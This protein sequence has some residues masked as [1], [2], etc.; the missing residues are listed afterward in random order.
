M[1]KQTGYVRVAAAVPET[2]VADVEQNTENIKSVLRYVSSCRPDVIIFPELCLTSYT[3]GD[4]FGHRSLHDNVESGLLS[5]LD[6]TANDDT[7]IVVGAPLRVKSQ[8]FN[9][10]VVVQSGKIL[11][12]VPKSF[13]PNYNEYYEKRWF[14]P[15]SSADANHIEACGQ[16]VPFGADIVFQ[17]QAEAE[18]FTFAVELCEDLWAPIPPSTN[19]ALGGANIL[20]NISASNDLVGKSSYRRELVKHQS[21]RCLSAYA[22]CSAGVGESTTDMVFGGQCIIAENDSV[23]AESDRF[24]RDSHYTV[25]DIDTQLLTHERCQYTTF[26][27]AVDRI[28]RDSATGT[29]SLRDVRFQARIESSELPAEIYRG[30]DALPFV[31]S[32]ASQRTERCREVF[33]IQSTGLAARMKHTGLNDLVIGLSGGLDSTHALLVAVEACNLLGVDHSKI[34]AI[35][36][37]GFGTSDRTLDNVKSLCAKLGVELETIDIKNICEQHFHDIG[38]D[39]QN[40]DVTYENV[41]ARERTR[42][43]M[44][45]ANMLNGLVVGTGDLSELAL[46]WCTYNG[47]HMSMYSVNTGVPKTLITFLV[48]YV[49]E[50]WD[51]EETESILNSILETPVTPELIPPDSQ[52]RITQRTEEA[53][54]PYEL[55]DFFLYHFIR[56]G[57]TAR[58]TL[59]LACL[60]FGESYNEDTI[61]KWLHVFIRRFFSNQFKRSCLPDGPKVGTIALSP[62][63]DW[64]MPSDAV[65]KG[66]VD[67]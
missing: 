60:A 3:C 31:P 54:G 58:K 43:L 36:M 41:Q 18:G 5:L 48:E 20:L 39:G 28:N 37:P 64:R 50:L 61:K 9:C 34:H 59:F 21:G 13:L 44:D 52:G 8:L 29:S 16:S 65:S 7:V 26:H 24:R 66:F 62:R 1:F 10:A 11:G 22:Y 6:E 12:A 42:I 67:E 46:G 53:I 19:Y 4:L 51:D 38:H 33:S 45:K 56:H 49:A 14:S 55:H 35:T 15:A 25:A 63:G 27:D 40:H 2:V 23:L 32:Q 17:P 30:V 57:F 47:D